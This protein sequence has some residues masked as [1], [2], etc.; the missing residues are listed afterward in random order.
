MRF[1]DVKLMPNLK[2][3]LRN[4]GLNFTHHYLPFPLCAQIALSG[5]ALIQATSSG[6]V[7]A[8]TEGWTVRSSGTMCV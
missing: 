3:L 7:L 6:T 1:D 5:F 4:A 2:A 8:G